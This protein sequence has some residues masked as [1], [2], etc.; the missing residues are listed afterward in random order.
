MATPLGSGYISNINT[1][2]IRDSAT[3]MQRLTDRTIDFDGD[4]VEEQVT[5]I[6]ISGH[7][8]GPPNAPGGK[9][10]NI[11]VVPS[12]FART[13]IKRFCEPDGGFHSDYDVNQYTEG[14]Q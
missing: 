12:G 11:T 2:Q 13:V 7:A 1:I 5:I 9:I 8:D 14:G 4:G 3:S 6:H 10:R